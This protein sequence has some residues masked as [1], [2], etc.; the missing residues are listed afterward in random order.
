MNSQIT[1]WLSEN[2]FGIVIGKEPVFG[3]CI[4]DS[5]RLIMDSGK[6]FFLKFNKQAPADMFTAESQGLYALSQRKALK[7]PTVIY[8]GQDFIL[9]EDLGDGKPNRSYWKTLGEGLANLHDQSFTKFGFLS[10]NY[11]GATLQKNTATS[12][13]FEFF[14]DYRILNLTSKA[15]NIN[16]LERKDLKKL[17]Y[18]AANL[19]RWI[20]DQKPVLIHGDLWRGNVHC[21]RNGNPALVDPA[22]YW[23]WAEAD[24]AM[25]KLFGGFD[26]QFYESYESCSNID[27]DWQK[28]APIYNLY[29]LLNHLILFGSSYLL[30][31]R[32]NI[33]KF[34]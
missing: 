22:V 3:G 4:N 5:S 12:N 33:K 26:Q 27:N 30:Q 8:T 20:P 25:T 11:C 6:S 16:L 21:D 14:S 2:G 15:F 28:R 10:D 29:H 34:L 9:L 1:N 7:T 13:G 32:T 23:G 18:I 24:L 19:Y 17:E 31:I